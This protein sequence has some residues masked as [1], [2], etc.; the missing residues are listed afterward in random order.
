[1]YFQ[2]FLDNWGNLW[3][4]ALSITQTAFSNLGVNIANNMTAIWDYISS[5]GMTALEMTWTPLLEGFESTVGDIATI[6]DRIPTELEKTLGEMVSGLEGQLAADMA[7]TMEAM[8]G[9]I[10]K[11]PLTPKVKSAESPTEAIRPTEAKAVGAAQQG[12]REALSA[13]FGS[14]RGE[15]Y[16]RQLVALQ[17]QGLAIQ[18]QQL[19]ALEGLAG[20]EGIGI[21]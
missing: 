2:W 14:M 9:A 6:S 12:T 10:D 13:I 15:D 16:Q 3:T 1:V 8:Q 11:R 5:G 20:E 17:Q 19:D 18:Q 4:D 21:D 7:G